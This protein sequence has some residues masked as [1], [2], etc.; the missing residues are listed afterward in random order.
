MEIVRINIRPLSVNKAFKGQ[1]FHTKEHKE[2]SRSVAW[3]LPTKIELPEPPYE[4]YFKFGFSSK[5]SDWD[6]PV[7]Q[8]QD[9]ISFK[10]GFNDKLIRRAVIETE[11]VPKGKEYF[12][13]E[14]TH[15][16]K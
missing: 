6:G 2:W 3:L 4:I 11:I 16:E 10:Y 8:C 7:K 12:E 14:L 5:L 13:F 15:Y 1:R 9:E